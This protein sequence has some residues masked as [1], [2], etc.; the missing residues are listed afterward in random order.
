MDSCRT[1]FLVAANYY[2]VASA[3]DDPGRDPVSWVL[4]GSKDGGPWVELDR[5]EN[6]KFALREQLRRD[7][8]KNP[9]RARAYQLEVL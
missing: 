3:N 2:T 6:Q 4:Y 9:Q 7:E 5:R 1:T 8:I